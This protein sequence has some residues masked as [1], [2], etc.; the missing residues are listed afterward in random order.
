M[1]TERIATTIIYLRVATQCSLLPV[2]FHFLAE[3]WFPAKKPAVSNS[4]QFT[5]TAADDEN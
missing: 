2:D 1:T 4:T 3:H 5:V